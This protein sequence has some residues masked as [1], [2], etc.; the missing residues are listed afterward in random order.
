MAYQ[1]QSVAREGGLAALG[2]RERDFTGEGVGSE[3][4]NGQ[5]ML[6]V[7]P[8]LAAPHLLLTS[9]PWQTDCGEQ[10][11]VV[12]SVCV[13]VVNYMHAGGWVKNTL[14]LTDAV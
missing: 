8:L 10:P 3:S 9:Q 5:K 1:A 2:R 4:G 13:T 6:V 11:V 12:R 7:T 14:Q